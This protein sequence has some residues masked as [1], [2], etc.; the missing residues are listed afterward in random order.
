[1]SKGKRTQKNG[2]APVEPYGGSEIE[3]I[4]ANHIH[5]V[6]NAFEAT[7]LFGRVDTAE[8]TTASQKG[9][10]VKAHAQAKIIIPHQTLVQL[11]NMME[12]VQI[13]EK[14]GK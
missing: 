9:Q 14:H 4:Y 8:A 12:Q 2:P 5:M 11:K 13:G 6:V 1:M 3:P 10:K 7:I